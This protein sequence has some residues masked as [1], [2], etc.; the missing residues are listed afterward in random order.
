MKA[1]IFQTTAVCM[2][3]C[4]LVACGNGQEERNSI[5]ADAL[6]AIPEEYKDAAEHPGTLN[7]L[8][9]ETWE[10]F[11]YEA[12]TQR[13]TKE[14]WV[15]LPYGYSEEQ[16]YNVFYLS[17]GGWSNE[18]TI[19]GTDQNPTYF[20]N[21]I[22]HAIE[23]GKMQPMILVFPTYNNTS[24]SDS[25]DYSL[26][27][28]LTDQFHQE[29]V[30]DLIPTVESRY[31]TYAEDVTPESLKASR[32]H[33]GFGGF[34]MGSVNTGCTFRYCLDYFRYFMPMSG[35]YT[36]DGDFMEEIVREQGY[37]P[38]D[39]FIFAAPGTEDFAYR[40]FRNQIDAMENA[41]GGIFRSG[42]SEPGGGAV[43]KHGNSVKICKG[44][45]LTL[46][47]KCPKIRQFLNAAIKSDN[48]RATS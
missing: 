26:A 3:V 45:G 2:T 32:S 20:K 44:A 5:S 47:A 15:Y 30:N 4:M 34:S 18:T 11:T 1:K 12:H 37:G 36:A 48:L 43:Q 8:V 16:Q 42:R 21:V 41:S 19:M 17:H 7:R 33:R 46:P 23:D 9:Y 40:A 31:S 22:D 28:Q 10:S 24:E 13:L 35:S 14:A 25:G 6:Q 38:E 29:L 27:L 39:F